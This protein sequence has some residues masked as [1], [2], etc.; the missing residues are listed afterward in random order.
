MTTPRKTN[1]KK[2]FKDRDALV[3]SGKKLGDRQAERN[4]AEAK[5][6]D[7]YK[8]ETEAIKKAATNPPAY[9]NPIMLAYR[10]AQYI[11]KCDTNMVDGESRPKPYTKKGMALACYIHSDTLSGYHRG[12][13]DFLVTQRNS[14]EIP[15]SRTGLQT[16]SIVDTPDELVDIMAMLVGIPPEIIKG[17]QAGDLEACGVVWDRDRHVFFS[18]VV[19]NAFEI[20]FEQRETDLYRKGRVADIFVAKNFLGMKD[21]QTITS[22][23]V[24]IAEDEAKKMIEQLNE[25]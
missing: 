9:T 23:R 1:I 21:E 10:I 17:A 24:M 3:E 12:D 5:Q 15:V 22:K 8:R 25:E 20:T 11:Y 4:K 6:R 18:E 2:T 16:Q 14:G 7:E 13:N 19:D